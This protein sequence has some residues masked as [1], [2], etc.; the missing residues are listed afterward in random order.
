MA[1]QSLADAVERLC[2]DIAAECPP[3]DAKVNMLFGLFFSCF[4]AKHFRTPCCML[5]W[6]KC[7][8][9]Q[10]ADSHVIPKSI[11]KRISAAFVDDENE[12]IGPDKATLKM[13]CRERS[14]NCETLFSRRGE[15]YF[16]KS[17]LAGKS[18]HLRSFLQ[19][20]LSGAS[21]DLKR[22]FAY[23]EH[24]FYLVVSVAYRVILSDGAA[25][26]GAIW[27]TMEKHHRQTLY[28]GL[29]QMRAYLL[30]GDANNITIN[31]M[32]DPIPLATQLMNNADDSCLPVH[33]F[34]VIH[35]TSLERESRAV[36]FMFSVGG[37]CFL[38]V[39]TVYGTPLTEMEFGEYYFP[40]SGCFCP[41]I[42]PSGGEIVVGD[43]KF[44][45]SMGCM[46]L[47][48]KSTESTFLNSVSRTPKAKIAKLEN[49]TDVVDA[50]SAETLTKLRAEDDAWAALVS[51][52]PIKMFPRALSIV[53]KVPAG[54]V[55]I[56]SKWEEFSLTIRRQDEMRCIQE[57][58][59]PAGKKLLWHCEYYRG[60]SPYKFLIFNVLTEERSLADV[61]FISVEYT[62]APFRLIKHRSVDLLTLSPDLQ[63]I[64]DDENFANTLQNYVQI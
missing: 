26:F 43:G 56:G 29:S 44:W 14:G 47:R 60:K 35:I 2:Q 28:R 51:T 10:L 3:S 25:E 45:L 62:T 38:M 41:S 54:V 6:K 13:L 52:T 30:G 40:S 36:L 49:S 12:V 22:P 61:V 7:E 39:T 57:Y 11:L 33:V 42:N 37:L 21:H 27:P 23:T 24:L 48:N 32:A 17:I 1:H 50:V 18:E 9:K 59:E 46:E 64:L 20:F 15:D 5:C 34:Q 19:G 4:Q 55:I 31:L 63:W 8:P 53:A 58:L 16:V